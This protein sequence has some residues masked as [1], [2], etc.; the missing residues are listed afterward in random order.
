MSNALHW[1]MRLRLERAANTLSENRSL[2]G[3]RHLMNPVREHHDGGAKE[4]A[5]AIRGNVGWC[6]RCEP[7]SE[8]E[9]M[10]AAC[11]AGHHAEHL[12]ENAPEVCPRCEDAQATVPMCG[13]LTLDEPITLW[14]VTDMYRPDDRLR[15]APMVNAVIEPGSIVRLDGVAT[16]CERCAAAVGTHKALCDL[17]WPATGGH[18]FHG[19]VAGVAAG[20]PPITF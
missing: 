2:N 10:C 3:C 4:E 18:G 15:E 5:E 13:V 11:T 20:P 16:L 17:R 7:D 12:R 8:A 14:A 19:A 6:I 1:Q 9:W